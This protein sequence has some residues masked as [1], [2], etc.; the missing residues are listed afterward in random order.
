[1]VNSTGVG[2][3]LTMPLA[4]AIADKAG[5]ELA[6]ACTGKTVAKGELLTTPGFDMPCD[7]ILHCNAADYSEDK[8]CKVTEALYVFQVLCFL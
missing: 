1:M 3:D 4:K 6:K 7:H 8:D 5:P 2:V